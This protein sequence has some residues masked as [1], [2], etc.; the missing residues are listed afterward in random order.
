MKHQFPIAISTIALI[1]FFTSCS[2]EDSPANAGT[3]PGNVP[4]KRTE[5][6]VVVQKWQAYEGN[7]FVSIFTN[8]IANLNASHGTVSVYADVNGEFKLISQQPIDYAGGTLSASV[9]QTD[10]SITF[11]GIQVNTPPQ[12]LTVK[13]VVQN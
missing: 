2:K 7:T 1:I 13:I 5:L 12:N 9:S 11:R 3:G 4:T 10:L 6:S 8:L